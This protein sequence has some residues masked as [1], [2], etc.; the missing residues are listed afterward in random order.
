MRNIL[1][2]IDFH[3]KTSV[4]ID[5]AREFAK[6]FGAKLWLVHIAAPDPDFVGYEVGPQYIRDARADELK[7]EHH[8]LMDY[9]KNLKEEGIDA[10]GLLVQGDIND[11]IGEEAKK[12]KVDLI[13]TGHHEHSFIYEAFFGSTAKAI[14]GKSDVPVLVMPFS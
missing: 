1:V 6:V 7:E 12:L 10:E 8:A 14:V 4:L 9:S 11:L 5:K 3:E 2:C 13:I